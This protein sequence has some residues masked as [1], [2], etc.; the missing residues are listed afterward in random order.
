MVPNQ[1]S[2]PRPVNRKSVALPLALPRHNFQHVN[3]SNLPH[4]LY[5]LDDDEVN[6]DRLGT[7]LTLACDAPSG[8]MNLSLNSV[9]VRPLATTETHTTDDQHT[10]HFG[11]GLT[12]WL[13]VKH[14]RP[15]I[16]TQ[17]TLALD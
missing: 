16:S 3:N 13:H 6:E 12:A 9:F 7:K 17:H 5:I 2:N 10:A 11:T 15:T 8:K 4:V 1:D 14:T